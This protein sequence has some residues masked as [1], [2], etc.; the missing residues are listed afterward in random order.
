MNS[1]FRALESGRTPARALR[2]TPKKVWRSGVAAHLLVAFIASAQSPSL[3]FAA[4][5]EIGNVATL[6]PIGD[7]W[8]WIPDVLFAHSLLFDGDS[9]EMMGSID[10]GSTLSP[11]PPMYSRA[12][13][14]FY[15]VEIDYARGRRGTRLDFVTIYDSKTLDVTGEVVLPTRTS[16]SAAS[17]G[18]A[19]L[20]D[21]DRFLATF[22]QFPTTSV[23]IVD[24][25]T[26]SFV[27]EI[28][29]SGCAGIYPTGERSF[30]M[31]C[32]DGSLLRVNL[33]AAGRKRSMQPT[34]PFF[35]VIEDP[36]VMAA[37]R[38]GHRWIFISFAGMAHE[39]DLSRAAAP[40]TSWPLVD[41]AQREAGWRPGGRQHVALHE[42]SGRL[43]V[44]FHQG[45]PGSHK[46]PGPE[47]WVFDLAARKRVDRFLMPNFTAAFIASLLELG[48]G[49][50]SGWLLE[51]LLP[52][53]GADTI[54][55]SQDAAPL[56]F[57]R[58]SEL[59]SV[60]V[61]D[62]RTGEHLRDLDEVGLAGMRLE[63]P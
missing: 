43:Y 37:G 47:V 10:A 50:F 53:Y 58:N 42:A 48:S 8:V 18:Y 57:A 52:S 38:S 17:L 6:P 4:P 30:A 60:A 13:G 11:K 24:L 55:V 36:V 51:M 5:E 61:L 19:A 39:V 21:G 31:L 1:E 14:E 9:G 25:E 35:D 56:L 23:S 20:L 16:E 27:D 44:V 28:V 2:G 41:D 45:G 33:D 59:G 3:V 29:T 63:V 22:N 54:A 46:D 40:V 32:G 15:S 26:R 7:H 49:G 34:K 62:A 12:R